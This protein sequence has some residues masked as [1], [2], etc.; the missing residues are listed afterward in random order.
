MRRTTVIGVAMALTTALAAA[1]VQAMEPSPANHGLVE[2]GPLP[3]DP[4]PVDEDLAMA[5]HEALLQAEQHPY[6]FGYPAYDTVNRKLIVTPVTAA[7]SSKVD[8]LSTRVTKQARQ[9]NRT[10][11]QL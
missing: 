3:S 5:Y 8:A 1:P 2:V 7:G 10:F 11:A 6:D 9:S 4:Q